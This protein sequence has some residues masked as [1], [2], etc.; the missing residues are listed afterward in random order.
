MIRKFKARLFRY[1]GPNAWTFVAVPKRF[2]V[3][4]TSGWGRTPVVATVDGHTWST[5]VWWDT[6][7]QATLLA[8]P[9]RIRG[10]KEDGDQVEVSIAF[11]QTR[12]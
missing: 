7:R 10:T 9:K 11:D 8:V 6:K 4:I 2:A 3:P 12:Q 5:S 1:P